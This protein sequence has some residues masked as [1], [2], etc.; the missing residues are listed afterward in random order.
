M[1]MAYEDQSAFDSRDDPARAGDYWASWSGYIAAL[2][3]SGVLQ[4]AGG[5]TAP[6]VATSVRL[7]DGQRLVQDG[8]FAE[9][10]EQ[11]GG[12]FV[13]DVADLDEAL[14]WAA[15]CPSAAYAGVEVRPM[16]PP[17]TA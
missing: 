13:I 5:L 12:Y 3:H 4:S 15:R 6:Q 8:P 17:P 16:L 2:E 1:I 14:Q 11:L 10:K 7:R 9:T